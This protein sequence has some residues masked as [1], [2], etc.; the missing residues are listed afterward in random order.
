[1]AHLLNGRDLKIAILPHAVALKA[2]VPDADRPRIKIVCPSYLDQEATAQARYLVRRFRQQ[3]ETRI[4]VIGAFWGLEADG[5]TLEQARIETRA[6]RIA[7]SLRGATE[8]VD[9][10]QKGVAPPEA[11]S[12]PEL[13]DLAHQISSVIERTA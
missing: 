11:D 5:E 7:I 8:A 9:N 13:V 1:L 12:E 4:C 10:A 6:D 2:T 3:V